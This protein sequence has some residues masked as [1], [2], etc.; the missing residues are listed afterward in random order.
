MKALPVDLK[1]A[2]ILSL[3]G[4][5]ERIVCGKATQLYSKSILVFHTYDLLGAALKIVET[6]LVYI[7][8]AQ[9]RFNLIK[10]TKGL[11]LCGSVISKLWL[12][13]K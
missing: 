11:N 6:W 3:L 7:L 12:S 9:Y 10:I 8:P 2:G 4:N 5:R 1:P 13:G